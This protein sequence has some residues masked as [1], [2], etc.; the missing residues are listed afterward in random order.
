MAKH[1]TCVATLRRQARDVLGINATTPQSP[2]GGGGGG[3]GGS[4]GSARSPT[5]PPGMALP[6]GVRTIDANEGAV[7]V[8]SA[9]GSSPKGKKST[10]GD[11]AAFVRGKSWNKAPA[12][13]VQETYGS[14]SPVGNGSS[15]TTGKKKSPERIVMDR[16][17]RK[18]QRHSRIKTRTPAQERAMEKMRRGN[19]PAAT[20]NLPAPGPSRPVVSVVGGGDSNNMTPRSF[21]VATLPSPTAT[22]AAT[23][24]PAP[25]PG[26][27]VDMATRTSA[28]VARSSPTVGTPPPPSPKVDV[29]HFVA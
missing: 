15:K 25:P 23:G 29:S 13:R 17:A 7:A 8:G 3:G 18:A 19:S 4:G 22:G 2:G 20:A 5:L 10:S 24:R 26:I 27:A 16:A 11:I 14:S 9:P 6:P 1:L 28:A 21:S 12:N